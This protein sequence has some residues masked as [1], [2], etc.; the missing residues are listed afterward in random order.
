MSGNGALALATLAE[1]AAGSFTAR[2]FSCAYLADLDGATHVADAAS[3]GSFT[4][5]GRF[6]VENL[7]G[8]P[9]GVHRAG[10]GTSR[11]PAERAL[12]RLVAA[13]AGANRPVTCVN[14]AAAPH[15]FELFPR[16]ARDARGDAADVPL[17]ALPPRRHCRRRRERVG[18][19]SG[20]SIREDLGERQLEPGRRVWS[21]R[22][23]DRAPARAPLRY[24][25]SET[26][27][28][29]TSMSGSTTQY[30]VTLKRS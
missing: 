23:R 29:T 12:D 25:P 8:R 13:H 28:R 10:P 30:S 11:T 9:A 1:L 24:S 22:R 2:V 18:G 19:A 6:R 17:R 16:H 15:G 21:A 4:Y 27:T 5:P 7:P 3:S 20:G 26:N 14:F